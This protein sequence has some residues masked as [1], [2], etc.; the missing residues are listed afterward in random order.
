[1]KANSLTTK[2][3]RPAQPPPNRSS[4]S[5]S[6]QALL[7]VSA[8]LVGFA[9]GG[10]FALQAAA[11]DGGDAHGLGQRDGWRKEAKKGDSHMDSNI[12][13]HVF[14]LFSSVVTGDHSW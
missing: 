1:M 6:V 9:L 13:V 4:F 3:P 14:C 8:A 12:Q 7:A 2:G 11:R 10:S 5:S